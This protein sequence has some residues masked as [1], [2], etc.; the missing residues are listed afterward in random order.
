LESIVLKAITVE[1]EETI[2]EVG[3]G[4]CG[5][6]RAILHLIPK[7]KVICIE[8]DE[9]FKALHNNLLQIYGDRLSFIYKDAL[10]IKIESLTTSRAVIISNLPYNVGTQLLINWLHSL[11]SV[12]KMV[13]MFQKEVA[14]RIC[15]KAGL[16]SYGRLSI[17]SQL[18]C[19]TNKAMSISN[20]SFYPRPKVD[21]AVVKLIPLE[22]W[23]SID[24]PM[25][26]AITG[27]CFQQRRKTIL[28]SLKKV[29][30]AEVV[31]EA[32]ELAG[33]PKTTRPE[34][35]SPLEFKRLAEEFAMLKNNK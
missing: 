16:K 4:P 32:L 9:S 13:L 30:D 5:L 11:A 33:I 19:E 12:K 7:C 18:L 17:I 25:L 1:D 8:K 35:I 21:S 6:T 23:E 24:I 34:S 20:K 14:D 26:E 28:N 27:A 15:S 3:P 10:K 31:E 2:I 29:F 22:A